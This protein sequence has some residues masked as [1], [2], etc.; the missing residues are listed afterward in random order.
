MEVDHTILLGSCGI[1]IISSTLSSHSP[2]LEFGL[3]SSGMKAAAT[4]DATRL[5]PN[6]AGELSYPITMNMLRTVNYFYPVMYV[7]NYA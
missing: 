5:F 3:V 1:L 6:F 7:C 4:Q 2:A